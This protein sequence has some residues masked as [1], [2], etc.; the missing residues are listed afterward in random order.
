MVDEQFLQDEMAATVKRATSAHA[1]LRE[2]PLDSPHY[3]AAMN[4][5][6]QETIHY[7]SIVT[8]AQARQHELLTEE[9]AELRARLDALQAPRQLH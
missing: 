9:V 5:Y 6:L 8:L 1:R 2:T 7:M 4:S 3:Q